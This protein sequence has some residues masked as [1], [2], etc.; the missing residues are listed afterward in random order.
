MTLDAIICILFIVLLYIMWRGSTSSERFVMRTADSDVTA[1]GYTS[2]STMRIADASV[3]TPRGKYF[4][5]FG[6]DEGKFYA[7][8]YNLNPSEQSEVENPTWR[9]AV[10]F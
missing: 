3:T 9:T 8:Y 6:E 10:T 4:Q 5:Q 1:P 7:R 2:G